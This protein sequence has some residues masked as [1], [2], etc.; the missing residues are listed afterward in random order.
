MLFAKKLLLLLVLFMS[1][2]FAYT[3]SLAV[4]VAQ[5][6]AAAGTNVTLVQ[7]GTELY[8]A[9]ADTAGTVQFNVSGG[10]YFVLLNRLG[11]P[12]HVSLVTVAQNT[13]ITL[14][15]RQQ[16]S[17]A[18]AYGQITG[19]Q[20]F[21]S[22][23][24][25]ASSNGQTV[26]RAYPSAYGNYLVTYLPEDDYQLAFSSDGFDNQ[27]VDKFLPQSDFT[28][29]NVA[30]HKTVAVQNNTAPATISSPPQI[31]QYSVIEVTLSQAAAGQAITVQTPSGTTT[32]KTGGD[33]QAHINAAESG[34]YTFTYG[35]LSTSTTV[36]SNAPPV[37]NATPP[38][39]N[40]TPPVQ[41]QPAAPQAPAAGNSALTAAIVLGAL[42]GIAV[43]AVLLYI[44][45]RKRKGQKKHD[46]A[47]KEA[48]LQE[49]HGHAHSQKS[50]EHAGKTH[51]H[52]AKK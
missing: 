41:Q 31:T 10:E 49:K 32:I 45:M 6:T 43:F 25:V 35:N 29:V 9:R 52:H 14:T 4:T 22:T 27:T 28:Q 47:E 19:P 21:S 2:S 7:G 12:L 15:M 42:A 48:P 8:N 24:I 40:Y 30:L 26:K 16:I 23:A 20:D 18:T 46:A 44:F 3:L 36:F 50:G 38:V 37:Q 17:Y 39:Q 1:A 51:K 5:G 13:N 33:G 11:Y 34:T